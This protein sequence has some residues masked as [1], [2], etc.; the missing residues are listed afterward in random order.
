MTQQYLIGQLSLLLADMA[1]PPGDRFAAAVHDL[2]GE[3]E[4]SPVQMLPTLARDAMVLSDV[5][6]WALW[7]AETRSASAAMRRPPSPSASSLKPPVCY[8]GSQ[9]GQSDGRVGSTRSQPIAAPLT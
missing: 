2:R 7:S 3:V 1:P 9:H 4:S 6:C 8:P 5:I